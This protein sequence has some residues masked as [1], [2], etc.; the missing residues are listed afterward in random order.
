MAKPPASS[1]ARRFLSA[2]GITVLAGGPLY[3]L[4]YLFALTVFSM[5]TVSANL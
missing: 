1:R 3:G 2:T 5:N 4:G